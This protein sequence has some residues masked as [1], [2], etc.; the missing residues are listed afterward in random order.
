MWP[1]KGSHRSNADAVDQRACQRSTARAA[2]G[3]NRFTAPR[4][5]PGAIGAKVTFTLQELPEMTTVQALALFNEKSRPVAPCVTTS[6]EPIA[7]PAVTLTVTGI[8]SLHGAGV[9]APAR[10]D[11]GAGEIVRR[12]SK[13]HD[14]MLLVVSRR[15]QRLSQRT[16]SHCSD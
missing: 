8:V 3:E 10:A 7:V 13:A 4:R 2:T 16:P 6:A 1:G 5:S 11:V 15:W 9:V 14:L 12:E